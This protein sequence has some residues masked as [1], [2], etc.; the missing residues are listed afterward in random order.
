MARKY[1]PYLSNKQ[2]KQ[3]QP[4]VKANWDELRNY[5]DYAREAIAAN[6]PS[7]HRMTAAKGKLKAAWTNS[8]NKA[9]KNKKLMRDATKKVGGVKGAK[10]HVL[11]NH[12]V[13]FGADPYHK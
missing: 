5:G 3:V 11:R 8:K 6:K 9:Q 2:Q 13:K 4:Y 10:Q 1:Y 12:Y 7:Q